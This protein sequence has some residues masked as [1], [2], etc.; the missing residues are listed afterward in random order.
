MRI[1]ERR[2]DVCPGGWRGRQTAAT[3]RRFSPWWRRPAY[4]R[5]RWRTVRNVSCPVTDL[6]NGFQ[7]HGEWRSCQNSENGL[8]DFEKLI[9]PQERQQIIAGGKTV[10]D[11]VK[12]GHSFTYAF[13][14]LKDLTHNEKKCGVGILPISKRLKPRPTPNWNVATQNSA[15]LI[16]LRIGTLDAG[17]LNLGV[18]TN[19]FRKKNC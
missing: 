14:T 15:S 13:D 9:S 18:A 12:A 2:A 17:K 6:R 1:A 19:Q 11:E 4:L 8:G 16:Q 3:Q 5:A 10:L 7:I